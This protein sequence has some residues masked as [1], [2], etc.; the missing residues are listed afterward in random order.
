MFDELSIDRF[1]VEADEEMLVF[2]YE[3]G[4][5]TFERGDDGGDKYGEEVCMFGEFKT[6]G[7][8]LLKIFLVFTRLFFLC[9]GIHF[10]SFS[11]LSLSKF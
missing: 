11:V 4:R 2:S 10:I 5:E 9:N 7:G 6:N 1:G 3:V 8:S